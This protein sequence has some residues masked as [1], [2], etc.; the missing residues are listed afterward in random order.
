M[1]NFETACKSIRN[2][3]PYRVEIFAPLRPFDEWP[4]GLT[5]D[6]LTEELQEEFSEELP[7]KLD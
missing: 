5:K 3:T 4:G 1:P 6:K 2:L 7:G